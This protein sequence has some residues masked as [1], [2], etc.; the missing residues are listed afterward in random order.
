LSGVE[1]EDLWKRKWKHQKLSEHLV[2]AHV[3]RS[4]QGM[5]LAWHLLSEIFVAFAI[6]V[7]EI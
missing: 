3:T 1:L 5:A 7:P 6:E 2:G 4:G